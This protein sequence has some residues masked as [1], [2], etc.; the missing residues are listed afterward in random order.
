[1]FTHFRYHETTFS[2]GANA[3]SGSLKGGI[4]HFEIQASEPS[5]R[6]CQNEVSQDLASAIVAAFPP[7]TEDAILLWNWV[8]VKMNYNADLSVMIEDLLLMLDDL[9]KSE[10]GSRLVYFGSNTFRAEWSLHWEGNLLR[11]KTVWESVAGMYESLLNSRSILEGER[12]DFVCEWKAILKKLIDSIENSGIAIVDKTDI[13]LLRETQSRIP[14][15]GR[16][17]REKLS[18]A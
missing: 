6:Q 1:V 18:R 5:V 4:L 12:Q 3:P 8:P 14:N 11:I 7:T 13:A 9:L 16:L 2:I 15:F 17:Y 10:C